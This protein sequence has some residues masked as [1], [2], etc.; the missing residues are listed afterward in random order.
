MLYLL[1]F[2]LSP[3]RSSLCFLA[4]LPSS[5]KSDTTSR[6]LMSHSTVSKDE[7]FREMLNQ[8][9]IEISRGFETFGRRAGEN[10]F[11]YDNFE[12]ISMDKGSGGPTESV[13]SNS[14]IFITK[15]PILTPE[16]CKAVI[17]DA[18]RSIE[19]NVSKMNNQLNEAK[20]SDLTTQRKFLTNLLHDKLFPILENAFGIDAKTMTLN[21]G[22]VL[23]YVGPSSE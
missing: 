7:I 18:V 11:T 13:L 14:N 9:A 17:A 22:L 15:E 20:L 10:R 2:F 3:L 6:L 4:P 1:L 8:H 5:S 16:E 19:S 23:H 12:V 21:D